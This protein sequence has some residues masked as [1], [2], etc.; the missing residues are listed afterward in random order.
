MKRL[1]ILPL[2]ACAV[3]LLA[4]CAAG[5]QGDEQAEADPGFVEVDD[6]SFIRDGEAYPY[7][8]VNMWYAA[9]LGA[10]APYG[11]RERL[12]REL[13]RL[14]ALG[15]TNLRILGASETSPFGKSLKV[16]FRDESGDYDETLLEGLDTALAEIGERGMTAVI[17]LNNF[18][19]WS[20][21]MG[22]YLSYVNGGEYI[23][24]GDP[25]YPWPAFPNFV[26][27]FY[28]NDE[29]NALFRDYAEA[30][31]TRTNSVTGTPYVDDPAIMAWQLANEP[32]PDPD[33]AQGNAE[34]AAFH[35]WIDETAR[36]IKSLDRNHLVST[37]NEGMMGCNGSAFCFTGAH[38]GDAIDYATFHMWPRNWSWFDPMDADGTIDGAMAQVGAYIDQHIA[39][40][41]ELGKPIVLEEFG[42]DRADEVLT[43]GS[44]S[45][46]RDRLLRA[47]Y[48]RVERSAASGGP[49]VGT[50]LWAWGGYGRAQHADGEWQPGDTSYTGDPPQEPQGRNSVFDVDEATLAIIEDHAEAI[51]AQ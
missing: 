12:G 48:D 34:M 9:Y 23:D 51:S 43:P 19:E 50:N 8:G 49:L 31:V 5:G 11:D 39:L 1:S 3:A 21:G 45:P 13:D 38:D 27:D 26:A 2:L 10:D 20:G 32:R 22:T 28:S 47:V 6:M 41:E 17:Y 18:W 46:H 44:P 30:V 36:F 14:K 42:L 29:A 25:A 16:T 33:A 37:G 35:A 24:L 4:G 7:V 40:A 15:V